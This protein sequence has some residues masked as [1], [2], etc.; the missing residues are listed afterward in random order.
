MLKM[1]TIYITTSKYKYHTSRHL[2]FNCL[3]P[4]YDMTCF[5][6]TGVFFQ[7]LL[8]VRLCPPLLKPDICYRHH[9][10]SVKALKVNV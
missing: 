9:M 3:S 6:L 5:C 4:T 8:Q 1:S 2:P 10:Y 7:R